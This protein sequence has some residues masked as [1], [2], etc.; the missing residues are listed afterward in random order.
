MLGIQLEIREIQYEKCIEALL[1]QLV[2]H[3]AAKSAP[4]DLDR[5]LAS[6][7]PDAVPAACAVLKTLNADERDQMV[8]WLTS[9]HEER[10]R[11]SANRHLAELT[12]G[13]MIHI[14]RLLAV[15]Q[16]GSRLFLKAAQVQIDYPALLKSAFVRDGIQQIGTEHALLKGAAK[17]A[18]QM[19]SR[20]SPE[21]L[22]KY[23]ITLLNSGK[24][25]GKLMAVLADGLLHAGLAITVADM[26]VQS[27]RPG[28][29]TGAGTSHVP[30]A[31][32]EK[33]KASLLAWIQEN[34]KNQK[35]SP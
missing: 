34:R 31:F 13:P 16:P 21:N 14:G 28:A 7:G 22:E 17:L 29:F 24:I 19:G 15:D 9:A 10:M 4:N 33:L 2:E 5:F 25:K 26:V 30:A 6:L 35:G 12:G 3:C 18:V 23:C 8:V 32:E 27:E 1:P 20:M 11:N